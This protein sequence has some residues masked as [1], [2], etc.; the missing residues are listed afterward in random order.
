[1]HFVKPTEQEQIMK[2]SLISLKV[3]YYKRENAIRRKC[4]I[5]EQMLVIGLVASLSNNVKTT[6]L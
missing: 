6:G 2:I 1:M 5:T 3:C 4:L